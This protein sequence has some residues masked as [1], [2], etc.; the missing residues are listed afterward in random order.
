[1]IDRFRHWDA[2]QDNYVLGD[3][4]RGNRQEIG[5]TLQENAAEMLGK[6]ESKVSMAEIEAEIVND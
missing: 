2:P 3:G 6:L 4:G 1:M 5:K